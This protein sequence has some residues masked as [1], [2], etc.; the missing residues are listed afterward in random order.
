MTDHE[1]LEQDV[2][3]AVLAGRWESQC[4][5]PLRAHAASC[6]SC[7]DLALVAGALQSERAAA[8]AEANPPSAPLV[9]WK[10]QL[11]ARREA[12]ERAARPVAVVERAACVF[13]IV[14]ALVA[15]LWLAPL[16]AGWLSPVGE[17]A[18]AQ[19]YTGFFSALISS[20]FAVALSI[21]SGL[22][23]LTGFL[24]YAVFAKH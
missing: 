22:L 2:L 23:C 17:A 10:A 14:A 11:R 16:V 13:A 5:E 15:L 12:T 1:Q 9:W 7:S 8:A 18:R 4:S 21:G 19:D 20:Q 24:L 3:E 6:A